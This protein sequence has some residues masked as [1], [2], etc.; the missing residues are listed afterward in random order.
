MPFAFT[1]AVLVAGTSWL[2][3]LPSTDIFTA[4]LKVAEDKIVVTG[5][6]NL[7]DN[8]RYDNQPFYLDDE[9]MAFATDSGEGATDIAI[10]DFKQGKT[11]VLRATKE[12]EFSPTLTPDGKH[13]S[14]IRVEEGGSQR[15]WQFPRDGGEPSLLNADLTTVGYH[16]W[17]DGKTLALFL[18][19]EPH[20]LVRVSPPD[21]T[22]T[23]L[24]ADID[25][26]LTRI[27]DTQSVAFIK[28]NGDHMFLATLAPGET[29]PTLVTPTINDRVDMV[30]L[31]RDRVLMA[32]G[33][34]IY[35]FVL[36]KSKQWE[37]VADLSKEG[38]TQITR[39]A[40][41]PGRT[42]IALVNNQ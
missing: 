13:L 38:P 24:A 31:S 34:V 10:H 22:P 35:Q 5:L 28:R 42:R 39:L 1:C 11:T 29:E 12:S 2:F 23:P 30:W 15:L 8:D 19:G 9:T 20:Q 18:V 37:K 3:Q 27:P 25:R 16:T 26:G 7:T 33:A 17:L 4:E 32:D 21:A 14:C 41:N 6:K 36:K 40:V